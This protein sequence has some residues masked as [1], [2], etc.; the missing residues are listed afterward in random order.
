MEMRKE[1]RKGHEDIHS[2]HSHRL[3]HREN[4][5]ESVAESGDLSTFFPNEEKVQTQ[6]TA[7]SGITSSLP[8]E[9]HSSF[10]LN[11]ECLGSTYVCCIVGSDKYSAVVKKIKML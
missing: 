8:A 5:K 6:K 4:P 3:T 7:N 1:S 10:L 9:R 2:L 11:V